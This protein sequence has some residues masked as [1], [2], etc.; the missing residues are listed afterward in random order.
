VAAKIANLP[1]GQRQVGKFADVPTQPEAAELLNVS[2]RTVRS[3][4]KLLDEGTPEL[5]E[6][7]QAGEV[8]VSTAAE[9]A[10]LPKEEQQEVVARGEDEI[11]KKSKEIRAKRWSKDVSRSRFRHLRHLLPAVGLGIVDTVREAIQAFIAQA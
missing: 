6:K 3:A 1:D 5:V 7:V 9:I 8:A 11:L 2:E 4:K 10:T